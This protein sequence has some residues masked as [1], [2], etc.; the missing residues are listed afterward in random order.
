MTT[1][2]VLGASGFIGQAVAGALESRGADVMALSAP[3]VATSARSL[4]DLRLELASGRV[5]RVIDRLREQLLGAAR[6]V[7]AAGVPSA[8]AAL[9]D[10]LMGANALLPA[11][12]EA[13]RPNGSRLVHI[14]SAAVQGRRDV[15]D[16]AWEW[17]PFSPY[18]TAKASGEQ[19]LQGRDDT[20]VYRPT[21]VHGAG[22]QVTRSLV[23]L[24]TSPLASVAGEGDRPTPQVLVENVGDAV[25]HVTLTSDVPP[26]VVL[27]PSEGLTTAELVRLVGGREPV[28]VPEAVARAIVRG[29]A[30]LG[31]VSGPAAAL[32]R[33][34][35]MLWWGQGQ[36]AG[37]LADRWTA[38][39]GHEAWRRLRE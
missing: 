24:L 12:V 6:V 35:D 8:G 11:V 37:W 38:P 18:S 16:E 17:E 1:V 19:L 20:A 9:D 3:R 33:R 21:S 32:G 22:R 31:R 29:A 34:I 14:S 27:H 15:L 13:A 23:R 25:A 26:P 5:T 2:A 36:V 7:N 10:A 30:V 39:L 4:D 28:H